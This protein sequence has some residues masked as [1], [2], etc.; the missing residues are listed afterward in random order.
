MS[1]DNHNLSIASAKDTS[2]EV[3]RQLSVHPQLQVRSAVASNPNTP[4]QILKE[5]ADTRFDVSAENV[6]ADEYD[7]Y[8]EQDR[9]LDFYT[10]L[11][12][13]A[14]NHNCSES[15][16][17]KLDS[18]GDRQT[19]IAIA[20]HSNVP[21]SLLKKFASRQYFALNEAIAQNPRTPA[22]L[23]EKL[24]TEDNRK[25]RN[26]LKTHPNLSKKAIAI[27]DFMDRKPGTT[28][29]LLAQLAED[30]RVHIQTRIVQYSL[31]PA[32]ILEK[33]IQNNIDAKTSGCHGDIPSL[34]IEH[35]NA[36]TTVLEAFAE[37]LLEKNQLGH[38][39][40]NACQLRLSRQSG[41]KCSKSEILSPSSI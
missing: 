22:T 27:I 21:V 2:I 3:L 33:L 24:A 18:Y 12:V 16:L 17:L 41:V 36:N 38:Y 13:V 8:D 31:T 30:R 15:L 34:V 40:D 25:I 10:L 11:R 20:Q 7:E 32:N 23:V 5:L 29:E 6:E 39:Q 14:R 37:Y 9:Y 28:V 1:I 19:E 4:I 26:L 35:P